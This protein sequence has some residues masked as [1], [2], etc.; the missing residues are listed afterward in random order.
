M[1]A[2]VM[3]GGE[4]TRLR[5][6]TSN[7]PKPMIPVLNKPVIEFIFELLKKH[8]IQ[9]IIVTLQFLPQSIKTYYGTG[10]DMGVHISYSI[11]ETPLGTAGSVK[12]ASEYLTETFLV[13]SGDALT[14]LDLEQAFKF[15]KKKRAALTIVLKSVE[16]PLEFGV[17]VTDS[18]GRITRFLEKPGWGEV[19]SDTVNTGIYIIEPEVLELVPHDA[20]FDFSKDLFPLLLEKEM[21]IFGCVLE[22]YWCDIGNLEQYLRSNQDVLRGMAKIEPPGIKMGENVW[23][24]KGTFLHPE[25]KISGPAV[26]GQHARIEAGA[27]IGELSVIGNNVVVGNGAH[28]HRAIVHENSYIGQRTKLHGCIVGR[29]C[30]IR[31]GA[32]LEQGVTI[33]DE[34]VI[35]ENSN[36]R[37]DVKVYPFKVVD[38]GATVN[39]SIIW[40]SRGMRALFGKSG[41]SGL[42]NIDITPQL[43]LKLGLSFGS[44]LPKESFVVISR[45]SN[46]ASRMVKR[47]IIAGLTATGIHVRD[48]RIAP[49]PVNRFNVHTTR[50]TGGIHVRTLPFS[51]QSLEINFYDEHGVDISEEMQRKIERNYFREEYRRAFFNEMGEILYS[52]RTNEFYVEALL[53]AIDRQSL[54]DCRLKIIID[55][56]RGSSSL[57]MPYLAGKMNCDIVSLNAFTDESKSTLSKE[58]FEQSLKQLSSMVNLFKADFGLLIDSASEKVFLV[59]DLGRR[60]SQNEF[61]HLMV[62]LVCRTEKL[63]GK[64]AVPLSVSRVVEQIALRYGRQVVRTKMSTRSLME[65]A[66]RKD[67]IFAGAQGGGFIFPRF[68]PSY[69]ALLTFCKLVEMRIKVAEPFSRIIDDMPRS[70]LAQRNIFCSWDQRGPVMRSLAEGAKGKDVEFLDGI[71]IF[72]ADG[73]VLIVPDPEELVLKIYA[74]SDTIENAEQHINKVAELINRYVLSS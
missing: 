10:S 11:E 61:L 55:H 1:K 2:V 33:G 34:C 15:H 49:A 32:T 12:N 27:E 19:F 23:I 40:E 9:D 31:M 54:A 5:P 72:S 65:T 39:T 16:N 64:I 41:V 13:I 38:D 70:F 24:G 71:K 51:P 18:D 20:P 30:D 14:D 4:G 35:G 26:I 29:N 67:I 58:E 68:M 36:I 57:V 7:Q 21:P 17:V 6:L 25:A 62:D 63:K 60:V 42:I 73:W 28:I 66:T 43:A 44:S 50:S 48:L 69:D 8:G 56:A 47:A 74:E 3:A 46:R 37:H 53:K 22:G 52:A 45:D 59:D